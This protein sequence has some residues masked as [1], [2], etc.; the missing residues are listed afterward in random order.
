MRHLVKIGGGNGLFVEAEHGE[1]L[2]KVLLDAGV[3]VA[4]PCNGA[5]RCGGC[6]VRISGEIGV[7]DADGG[8]FT[9]KQLAE[10]WRLCCR[11]QVSADITVYLPR[12]GEGR[13]LGARETADAAFLPEEALAA[14]CASPLGAAVD[15]GTTTVALALYDLK[16]GAMIGQ[17]AG[18][19]RQRGFGADVVSRLEFGRTP[20]GKR[21][22]QEAILSQIGDMARE[23]CVRLGRGTGEIVHMVLTGNTVMMHMALG[24]DYSGLEKAPFLPGYTEGFDLPASALGL[25][26]HEKAQVSAPGV[27]GAYVGADVLCAFLA[28][29]MD[30]QEELCVLYDIGTN[31]EMMLSGRDGIFACATAAGP[32]FE[33]ERIA[34]GMGAFHGAIDSVVIDPFVR[35]GIIGGGSAA[36]I[37]GSGILDAAFALL[38]AGLMDSS[39]ALADT[40]MLTRYRGEK[41]LALTPKV[42]FTQ[43]DV[44]QVQLAKG[45]IAAGM[46]RLMEQ[47]GVLEQEVSKVYIA[48]GFGNYMNLTSACGIGLI[49]KEWQGKVRYVGNGALNGAAA[50]LLNRGNK[51]RLELL[52]ERV[53][54]IELSG[55]E[56]FSELFMREMEFS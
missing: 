47:A 21:A 23:A 22:L 32:A 46:R 3:A 48:G 4:L 18:M 43:S 27:A 28:A 26:F 17:E 9:Q 53:S 6:G 56:R 52:R 42:F 2:S 12:D 44:R 24:K 35:C 31:G 30:R 1:R 8:F 40:P 36:G 29:G 10:G 50:I 15:I 20:E 38:R 41:A 54:V 16:T 39:G 49:P 14:L 25:D 37:C 11:A 19:N 51:R 33:G 5:G 13:I 55:D 45:A 34:F 7:S